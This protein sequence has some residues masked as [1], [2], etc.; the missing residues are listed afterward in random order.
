MYSIAG[1][2][3]GIIEL[4]SEADPP[5]SFCRL[6]DRPQR[7]VVIEAVRHHVPESVLNV[8][9][10]PVTFGTWHPVR[11]SPTKAFWVRHSRGQRHHSDL[12]P[13]YW[14]DIAER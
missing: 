9:L 8:K 1:E 2:I 5:A 13:A 6:H 11:P 12:R 3:T 4:H 10:G 7:M 14:L